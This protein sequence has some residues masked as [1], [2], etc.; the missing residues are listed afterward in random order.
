MKTIHRDIVSA[1][2][3]SKDGKI[4]QGTKN[5]ARGGVYADCWHLPGG[6]VDAG[7]TKEAALVREIKEETGI[8]IS[9]RG[10]ELIDNLGRG[11]A[12]KIL[13]SGEKVLCRMSFFVYKVAVADK[14]AE[15]IEVTLN[16]DLEKYVWTDI[17][18]LKNRKLTPPSK[19]LFARLGYIS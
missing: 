2:I 18:D 19:E 12:E 13:E 17:Q 10:F 16:D 7:E 4:F 1:L 15:E 6:G 3:V 11:E 8:H 9:P 5:P 14:T